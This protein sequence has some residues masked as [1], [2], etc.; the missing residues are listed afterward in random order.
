M[1]CGKVPDV[2]EESVRVRQSSRGDVANDSQFEFVAHLTFNSRLLTTSG[3]DAFPLRHRHAAF[4][5]SAWF[6]KMPLTEK[7]EIGAGSS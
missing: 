5:S 7:S 1:L 4:N 2:G 6:F 3:T